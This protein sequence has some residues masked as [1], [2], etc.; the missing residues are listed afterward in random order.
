MLFALGLNIVVGYA[1]LLDLGYVGVLGHRRLQR[2]LVHVARSSSIATSTSCRAAPERAGHPHQLL[3][4]AASSAAS[5][6]PRPASSS[7][8]P[9]LRLRGDYLAIV[10]LG[11]GEIVPQVFLN[12]DEYTNG[13][14]GITPID[15]IGLGFLH[16]ISGGRIPEVVNI[17]DLRAALLHHP[18]ASASCAIYVS[19]RL[20]DGKLGRAWIAIREDELAAGAMGIPLMRTKLWAYARRRLLRRRRRRLLRGRPVGRVPDELLLQHLDPHAVHG[21][22]GRDG[23]RVGR[24]ARGGAS[25]PG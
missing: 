16:T 17:F 12:L 2:R 22:P 19:L 5:R 25:S 8:R 24:H 1:G 6:A 23:E 21:H 9:T 18:R 13:A 14:R 10:T 20:R 7:A 11:F 3:D 4:R 15:P